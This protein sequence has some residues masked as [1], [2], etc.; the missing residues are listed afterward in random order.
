MARNRLG[1][2]FGLFGNIDANLGGGVVNPSGPV[3]GGATSGG[4]QATGRQGQAQSFA[5]GE[6]ARVNRR[7]TA[8]D[9]AASEAA[10]LQ[11]RIAQ[12]AAAAENRDRLD[13]AEAFQQQ[14]S[15][16]TQARFE[17]ELGIQAQ[18]QAEEIANSRAQSLYQQN[19]GRGVQPPHWY[20]GTRPGVDY[21]YDEGEVGQQMFNWRQRSDGGPPGGGTD[22][23]GNQ[24]RYNQSLSDNL[25]Q[26]D[27]YEQYANAVRSG[28]G[29]V[30]RYP[31]GSPRYNYGTGEG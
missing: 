14:E 30:G 13:R 21:A 1:S 28:G 17:Q 8:Q 31:D 5:A 2:V 3:V 4:A 26:M 29:S 7:Q 25:R 19:D 9:T 23:I 24:R 22:Y 18:Q 20:G 16:L 6:Q 10:G 12:E 11:Q 27:K 15:L